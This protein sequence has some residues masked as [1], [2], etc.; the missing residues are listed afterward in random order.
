M[1][2]HLEKVKTLPTT[3]TTTTTVRGYR[4]VGDASAV[5]E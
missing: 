5:D 2:L 3:T 4:F 1:Q